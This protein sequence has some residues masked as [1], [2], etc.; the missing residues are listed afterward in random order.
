MRERTTVPALV[1]VW[2]AEQPEKA[3]VVTDD[4]ALTY[5]E[6]DQRSAAWAARF[7]ELGV[8]KGTRVGVLMTNGTGWPVV[9]FGAS[10]AGAT[11]VPLSTFLRP[12]ELAAQLRTAGVE[13]LVLQGGFLARDYVAD[14]MAISP[15]LVAGVPLAVD[16]LPRLRTITLWNEGAEDAAPSRPELVDALDETV[17]PSDDLAIVFTSGSRGTPKG[18]IHTH[19]G[20]L[21]ATAAGLDVRRL[22]R[23]DRLYIPMPF[24]WV[25]G[26]GTGLLST[27]IVGAT[28]LTEARPEPAH[29]LPFLERERV[30]LFRG[31]PDQ[32]AALAR[33]PAFASADL[34][35]LRP[36]S[37][38]AVMP[39]GQRAAP[40]RRAGLLGM[41]ES[42]GPYSGSRLDQVLPAGK[43]GSCGQVFDG[44]EV[45]VVDLDT[46]V[47]LAAGETG[48]LQLRG[49]NLMRGICGRTRAEVF[50]EDEY[51]PTGDV[52]HLDA[53]GF[54]F[55]TGR[56]DD[57][58]KVRGAT[59]Y[60]GEVERALHA[61]PSVRRAYVVDVRGVGDGAEVGAVVVLADGADGTPV[62]VL[63]DRLASDA[64]QRLSSFKVPT[65]WQLIGADDVPMT[66]TGKVDKA[67]LQHLFDRGDDA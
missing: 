39:A 27:L 38:D 31:W 55:L 17:R 3:F 12:P 16:A 50:T 43:E 49:P 11:I 59:V 46:G 40:G 5:G 67:G 41:T 36:G 24:F 33:D 29:T 25:G 52:G 48:E 8:G 60:P 64:K 1:R 51:Y 18:V 6:L 42:F 34:S 63:V 65:R 13:H 54:L 10:R 19:G 30:T 23:D 28:L 22:T 58:F 2:A 37:L 21:A 47:P 14:L 9:A 57:M 45:R 4:A 56:R 53:D 20:A 61:L 26:F 66:T 44:V 35:S 15:E 7:A 32:A 62:D